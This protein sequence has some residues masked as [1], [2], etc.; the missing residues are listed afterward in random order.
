M[1]DLKVKIFADTA[2]MEQML[3]LYGNPLVKG[4]TTNPTLMRRA[5]VKH[6]ETFARTVV[7]DIPTLPISFQVTADDFNDMY[8]QAKIISSWGENVYVKIPITNTKGQSSAQ[9]IRSLV[10]MGIKLNITAIFT[11][12]QAREASMALGDKV[13]SFVS[14]FGG[15]IADTGADSA[16]IVFDVLE[17]LYDRDYKNQQ[18]IWAGPRELYWVV[19]ANTMGCKIITLTPDLIAKLPVLGKDLKEYSLETVK[20]FHDDAVA[21]GYSLGEPTRGSG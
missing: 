15:R 20:M 19:A 10:A 2:D 8:R 7:A 14:V 9:L 1:I 3:K 6:Y 17:D 12:E 4:Y 16:D 11:W 5:G 18:V 21:C 13:P